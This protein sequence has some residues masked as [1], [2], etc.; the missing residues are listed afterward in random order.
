MIAPTKK[1]FLFAEQVVFAHA[2]E[3]RH[4]TSIWNPARPLH[5]RKKHIIFEVQQGHCNGQ[6]RRKSKSIS[7]IDA[8]HHRRRQINYRLQPYWYRVAMQRELC[9]NLDGQRQCRNSDIKTDDIYTRIYLLESIS[10]SVR[11]LVYFIFTLVHSSSCCVCMYVRVIYT[12]YVVILRIF[13]DFF[14]K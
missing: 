1:S 3:R 5:M 11:S 9:E 7:V 13:V 2:H 10:G 6:S 14:C 8:L 4:H 12:F